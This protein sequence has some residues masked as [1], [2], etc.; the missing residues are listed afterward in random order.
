MTKHDEERIRQLFREAREADERE[1]PAFGSV[2]YRDR[3]G[4]RPS[5]G[6]WLRPWAIVA[7]PL[8]VSLAFGVLWISSHDSPVPPP[9]AVNAFYWE[10][11]TEVYLS[12][13]GDGVL[14]YVA[15]ET[16]VSPG[17]QP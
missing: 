2:L 6:R 8:A 3:R 16:A 1:A 11:P 15:A 9:L 12:E 7:A 13:P 5:P 17:S 14:S 4:R 10:S